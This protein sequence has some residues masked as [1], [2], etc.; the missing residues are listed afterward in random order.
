MVKTRVGTREE[1]IDLAYMNKYVG[2]VNDKTQVRRVAHFK[3]FD[4]NFTFSSGWTA[5]NNLQI[6]DARY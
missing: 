3:L 2:Y 4:S 6:E 5:K 1:Q